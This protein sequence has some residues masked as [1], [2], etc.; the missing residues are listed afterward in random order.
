LHFD[1][2]AWSSMTTVA[3]TINL[4][5]IL[6]GGDVFAVGQ[7]GTIWKIAGD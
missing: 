4:S 3:A 7:L 2:T 6:G 1:G 5:D